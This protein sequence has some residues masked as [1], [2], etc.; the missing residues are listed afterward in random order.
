MQQRHKDR[1]QYFT[2]LSATTE[3]YFLPYLS[4]YHRIDSD[5]KVLEIGCGEGGNLLPFAALGCSVTGVDI[6][7]NRI[8]QA[9]EYFRMYK[10]SAKF[11]CA[12][13]FTSEINTNYDIIIC[14]DVF[15][16]IS[17]KERLLEFCEK[18]LSSSG[19]VFMAFPAWSMPFGGHQQ[20]C[21]NKIVSKLPFIHLFPKTM[22]KFIL[23][24]FSEQEE[25]INELFNIRETRVSIN[26]FHRIVKHSKLSIKN[27]VFWLINPHYKEKFGLNPRKLWKVI[28]NIPYLRDFVTSSF[29]CILVADNKDK[30]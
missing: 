25:C 15:E 9:K 1:L 30:T 27:K 10:Y 7:V 23:T 14:H 3:K 24:C 8:R 22:Y 18:H 13:I 11:I 21:R 6:S 19:I 16:H 12:D 20:I 28:A 29:M 4:K 17:R 26:K 5:I 2:E